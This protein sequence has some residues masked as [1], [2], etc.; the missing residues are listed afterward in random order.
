M[1]ILAIA[2]ATISAMIVGTIWYL[3]AVTG[4][5]FEAVTGVDPNKPKRRGLVYTLTFIGSAIT[6]VVLWLATNAAVLQFGGSR[7]VVAL[8]TAAVLWLGFTAGRILIHHLFE[9]RPAALYPIT[10]G[11]ELV[12]VL[13]MAVIIGLL[14]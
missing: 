4:R 2:L 12:T 1:S 6:A 3:P 10:V 5:K 11:H 13:A 7:L 8:V 14:P 9:Q